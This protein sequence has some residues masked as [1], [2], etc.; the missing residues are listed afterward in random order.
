MD[1]RFEIHSQKSAGLPEVFRFWKT[2]WD[3]AMEKLVGHPIDPGVFEEADYY[4]I[5][6]FNGVIG[7]VMS[8]KWQQVGLSLYQDSYYQ[9]WPQAIDYLA[10]QGVRQFH[11]MGMIV[12]DPEQIPKGFKITR[13]LIGCGLKFIHHLGSSEGAVSFPRMG[14]SVSQACAE[15]GAELIKSHL[16]MYNVSVNFAF[17]RKRDGILSHPV[18]PIDQQVGS[19]WESRWEDHGF[20]QS[21]MVS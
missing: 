1:I 14:T 21:L 9:A 8:S 11:R 17:L 12:I 10:S 16:T 4:Y 7:A 2:R 6:R 19:L 5:L 13:V 20:E 15:W 3:L 18:Q